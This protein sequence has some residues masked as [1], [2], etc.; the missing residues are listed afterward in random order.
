MDEVKASFK[1]KGEYSGTTRFYTLSCSEGQRELH[2]LEISF[3]YRS[4]LL[5]SRLII[6]SVLD[7]S[8][9]L[10]VTSYSEVTNDEL[11]KLADKFEEPAWQALAQE[12]REN[13]NEGSISFER[14]HTAAP[15]HGRWPQL[16]GAQLVFDDD[17]LQLTWTY[18]DLK[19]KA[20]LPTSELQ[21]CLDY[22][23]VGS[24]NELLLSMSSEQDERW[25]DL[26]RYFE[27][28]ASIVSSPE[29][30]QLRKKL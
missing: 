12:F 27:K 5:H 21:G 14:R 6:R 19:V 2:F 16:G 8:T 30:E 18:D 28:F 9:D 11:L 3:D 15:S 25:N 20:L 7:K 13:C 22:L 1:Q 10:Q 23:G 24:T 26:C 4:D 29:Q 17:G